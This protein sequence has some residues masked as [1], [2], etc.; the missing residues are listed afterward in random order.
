[1]EIIYSLLFKFLTSNYPV[2]EL[3]NK[4]IFQLRLINLIM[5]ITTISAISIWIICGSIDTIGIKPVL[6]LST[7]FS[8]FIVIFL[9]RTHKINLFSHLTLINLTGSVFIIN[10]VIG[11]PQLSTIIWM[12]VILVVTA[13]LVNKYL[14]LYFILTVIM[15][16]FLYFVYQHQYIPQNPISVETLKL[17]EFT[18]VFLALLTTTICLHGFV[19]EHNSYSQQLET[20][21]KSLNTQKNR[22]H[23]MALHDGLTGL[24]NREYL[25]KELEAS[26]ANIR[27]DEI[28]NILYI[29][30]DNMKSINDCYGHDAGD[31]A[32]SMLSKHL[33]K[34]FRPDDIIA[35]MGGDEF[36]AVVKTSL[37]QHSIKEFAQ[38]VIDVNQQP[39]K[40]GENI[41]MKLTL[42]VGIASYPYEDKTI[43]EILKMADSALY[44]AKK[45]GRN[46]YVVWN[47]A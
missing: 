26:A 18:S 25:N 47:E 36:V 19:H 6:M 32:L 12:L 8:F 45:S 40:F 27:P 34:V 16:T 5:V 41:S 13:A 10:L 22:Y 3:D 31:Y 37:K 29:D 39:L 15:V 4:T 33:K 21:N 7:I 24:A 42:S 38:Q 11:G 1:M 46:C 30:L 35:R 43:T 20:T 14:F 44:H 28:I 2:E 9:R 17:L 23:F